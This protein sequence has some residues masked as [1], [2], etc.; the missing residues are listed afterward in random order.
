MKKRLPK[1]VS[2]KTAK[3]TKKISALIITGQCP[4]CFFVGNPKKSVSGT[5]S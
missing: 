4:S 3:N 1:D 5:T 2:C